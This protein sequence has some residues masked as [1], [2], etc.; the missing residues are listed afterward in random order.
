MSISR[1]DVA[2]VLYAT[3]ATTC[4][5]IFAVSVSNANCFEQTGF[6][7]GDGGF[8]L[9]GMGY[10]TDGPDT[11]DE[12]LYIGQ[13]GGAGGGSLGTLDTGN[14]STETVG[15]IYG[16]PEFT[17]NANGELWGFFPQES[18]PLIAQIDKD[19]GSLITEW[20]LDEL[21]S[22]A[23]AWAFAYWGGSYYVFYKTFDDPSTNVYK[24]TDGDMELYMPETGK[25]IVGAGVST[26]APT[27]PPI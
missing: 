3:G 16:G 2:Y 11:S 25:Y 7:C 6:Q 24:V 27:S 5:G 8:E 10:S 23:N 26:C 20:P 17:G 1:E 15:T 12:S 4:Y 18:P 21:S 14:W 13:I 19:S 9:F 22:D